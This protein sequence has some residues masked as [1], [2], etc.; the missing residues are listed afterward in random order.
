MKRLVVMVIMLAAAIMLIGFC[1]TS[2]EGDS[3]PKEHAEQ[4]QGEEL[5]FIYM[6]VPNGGV[7]ALPVY[8]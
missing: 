1:I 2:C 5:H 7:T 3:E 6:P 8:Y 4:A